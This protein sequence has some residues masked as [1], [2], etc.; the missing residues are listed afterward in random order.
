MSTIRDR[1]FKALVRARGRTSTPTT[2]LP[3]K[4]KEFMMDWDKRNKVLATILGEGI[5]EGRKGMQAVLNVMT[6]RLGTRQSRAT[7]WD[8]VSEPIQ[9]SAFSPQH[10]VYTKFRNY[11]RGEQ[12]TLDE[13]E[14]G[15]LNEARDLFRKAEHGQLE[16]ITNGAN[17]Y[18]NPKL[19]SPSWKDQLRDEIIIGQHRFGKVD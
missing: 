4:R 7:I 16:D 3:P 6:N 13:T 10:R 15:L 14:L 2:P 11:L 5:A 1:V 12:V 19:A 8:V 18:Y 17:H 9:F